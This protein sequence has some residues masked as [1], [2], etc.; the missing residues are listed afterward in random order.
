MY[1]THKY[2]HM[3]KNHL[4]TYTTQYSSTEVNESC[5]CCKR[6]HFDAFYILSQGSFGLLRSR[7][8]VLILLYRVI[9][10]FIP[11]QRTTYII[12]HVHC[13]YIQILQR[14]HCARNRTIS[15]LGKS[16]F[17]DK[18]RYCKQQIF[19]YILYINPT[20]GLSISNH[21]SF[22]MQ[23]IQCTSVHILHLSP[24]THIKFQ[25]ALPFNIS[26][27]TNHVYTSKCTRLCVQ[28]YSS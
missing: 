22:S 9:V 17:T 3:H 20:N 24:S 27:C 16:S 18:R 11:H 21:S 28:F 2:K 7:I 25:F 19:L 6:S 8:F 14:V 13:A 26:I 1:C 12:E 4:Y 10:L 23:C 5:F 15:M